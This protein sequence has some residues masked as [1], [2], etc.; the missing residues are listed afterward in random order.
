VGR[1][2]RPVDHLVFQAQVGHQL[3]ESAV[4][5]FQVLE[6]LPFGEIQATVLAL[7]LAK[8]GLTNAILPVNLG[9]HLALALLV[10]DAD[11]L[12]F[13]ETALLHGAVGK[14]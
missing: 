11:K 5:F 10:Q 7:P 4:F 14:E 8:R 9:H 12:C 13:A 6:A 3:L 2:A 1:G